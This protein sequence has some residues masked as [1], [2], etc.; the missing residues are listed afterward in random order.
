LALAVES[1]GKSIVLERRK[2]KV[3]LLEILSKP[4]I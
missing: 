2:G 1:L 4:A 3:S